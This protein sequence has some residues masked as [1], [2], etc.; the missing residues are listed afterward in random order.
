M[1]SLRGRIDDLASF[2]HPLDTPLKDVPIHGYRPPGEASWRPR[3]AAVL[4]PILACKEPEV[5]LTVRSRQ[6]P[7]HAGQ[8]SLPGGG[9]QE[10]EPFP[11]ETAVRETVE[12]VGIGRSLI[13]P[14]GLL[15]RFDTITGYRVAPVVALVHGDPRP[16]PCPNEVESVFCLPWSQVVHAGT[17][18]RHH[19]I[20][21]G[22][23][24]ELYSMSSTP[25]LVWGAT[26][27][28]L[29]QL[30]RL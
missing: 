22:H 30:S 28:I 3:P 16:E 13:E 4:I 1:N 15:D 12:E 29:H 27:A 23:S 7:H 17:Y 20:R 5:L 8:V 18:R 6:L 26:A 2:L 10:G 21:D 9:R 11:V 19:C 25:R 14:L 24:Y